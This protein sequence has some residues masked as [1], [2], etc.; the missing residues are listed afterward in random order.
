MPTLASVKNIRFVL[1]LFDQL[2]YAPDK[3]MLVLNR[4]PDDRNRQ[5]FTVASDKI[6]RFLKRPVEV[7]IP[8]DEMTVLGAMSKGVPVV[9]QRDRSRSPV[10][11]LMQL[12]ELVYT[13]LMPQ[14]EASEADNAADKAKR[15]TG[16]GLRFGKA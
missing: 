14:Q 16:L 5:K 15:K 8:S 12:S 11:E 13:R 4:V 10:K 7:E 3:S 1:D 9:A 6:E 2:T